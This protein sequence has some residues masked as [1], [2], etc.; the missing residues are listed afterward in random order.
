[1]NRLA[2]FASGNGTNAQNIIEYF[3]KSDHTIVTSVYCNN[4][5][6]YVLDRAKRLDVPVCLFNKTQFYESDFVIEN[7]KNQ[8]VDFI[9]LAGF[10]WLIP[11]KLI[12][13]FPERII[14]IHPALLPA[15]GG[16]GMY[17]MAVHKAVIASGDHESGISIHFVDEKYDHG[18]IIF[19][20]RCPVL[21]GDTAEML[22]QK[23]HKLEYEHFPKIIDSVVLGKK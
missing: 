14:N 12:A 20:S 22:A 15:Y 16:K 23:I 18:K 13:A 2:I 21:P 19:Q 11:K 7:L 5:E 6:A 8:P 4:P 10:L 1:M 9:I 17:G 3:R